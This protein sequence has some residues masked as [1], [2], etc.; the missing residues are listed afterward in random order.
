MKNLPMR[1][2]TWT[3]GLLFVMAIALVFVVPSWATSMAERGYRKSDLSEAQKLVLAASD[4]LKYN[5]FVA[6]PLFVLIAALAA[7]VAAVVQSSSR[8]RG[9]ETETA[10]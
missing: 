6:L 9:F 4:L 3:L 2:F 1:A 5:W 7:V 8:K 10:P